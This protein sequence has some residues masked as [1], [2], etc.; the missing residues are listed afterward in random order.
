MG[1]ILTAV[2]LDDK[3][4]QVLVS[5]LSAQDPDV[6]VCTCSADNRFA[7]LQP[8]AGRASQA[9]Y[10]VSLRPD[11]ASALSR[12]RSLRRSSTPVHVVALDQIAEVAAALAAFDAGACG[13]LLLSEHPAYLIESIRQAARGGSP[14]SPAAASKLIGRLLD[15]ERRIDSHGKPTSA[16]A[17]SKSNLTPKEMLVLQQVAKGYSY[18]EIANIL[19]VSGHTITSHAKNLYRK[20]AVQSRGEAVFEATQ[21]GLIRF[22]PSS[23]Q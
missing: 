21:L 13:Y 10:L 6:H 23:G 7:P 20:L 18:H 15:P 3:P 17:S 4:A 5:R 11:L 1:I 2:F 9:I 22:E 8:I 19:Q 16:A 12:I 14:I